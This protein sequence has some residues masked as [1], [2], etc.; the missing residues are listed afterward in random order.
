MSLNNFIS[1]LMKNLGLENIEDLE[2]LELDFDESSVENV[3]SMSKH[4]EKKSKLL[5]FNYYCSST[6]IFFNEN[7][8]AGFIIEIAPLVGINHDKLG[9]IEAFLS[10]Q[11]PQGAFMQFLMLATPKVER[12][13]GNNLDAKKPLNENHK[14][15]LKERAKYLADLSKQA[16][17]KDIKVRNFRC[18]LSFSYSAKDEQS[19]SEVCRAVKKQ[20]ESM[21]YIMSIPFLQLDAEKFID[22]ISEIISL[23]QGTGSNENI[24][25]TPQKR[26]AEHFATRKTLL[27]NYKN[28][29]EFENS[30]NDSSDNPASNTLKAKCFSI[31]EFPK[32]VEAGFMSTL[33][34]DQLRDNLNVGGK[35]ALSYTICADITETRK[36]TLSAKGA[37][38]H[39]NADSWFARRDIKLQAEANE[40]TRAIGDINQGERIFSTCIQILIIDKKIEEQEQILRSLFSINGFKIMEEKYFHLQALLGMLPMVFATGLWKQFKYFEMVKTSLLSEVKASLPIYAEWKGTKEKGMT[41]VARRGQIFSWS[42]FEDRKNYNACVVAPSG[43]GKSVFIQDF[44]FNMLS[45]NT[46]VF[47]LDIGRSY[48]KMCALLDGDFIEFKFESNI[49]LN[50]FSNIPDNNDVDDFL[51]YAKKTVCLMA[52]PT[53]NAS[54]LEKSIIEASIHTAWKKYRQETTISKIVEVLNKEGSKEALDI[55]KILYPFTK[56]GVYG[57]FFE[58]ESKINFKNPLTVIEFEEIADREELLSV[59]M[60]IVAIQVVQMFSGTRNQRFILVI[61]EAWKVMDKF[62]PLLERFVRTFRKYGG[63][64]IIATQGY[65]DFTK[66]LSSRNI[67]DN[68]QWHMFL[69]HDAASINSLRKTGDFDEDFL[70]V[71]QTVKKAPNKYSEV[72]ISSSEETVVGR[73]VLDKYSEALYST[74]A[75]NFSKMIEYKKQ[76]LSIMEIIE[77]IA[78]C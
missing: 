58:A 21:C 38:Y 55:A 67:W 56:D 61:D 16:L 28:N 25:Y 42:P 41:L 49:S 71:L 52:G 46:K 15:L 64:L 63:S 11:L 29:L 3:K 5:P 50:P 47:I 48:Q 24:K 20:I 68:S 78:E 27:Q 70:S 34:G 8:T 1:R 9:Q 32:E 40:W 31:E 36:H 2:M 7:N 37:T 66:T 65:V 33:I 23:D 60:Q 39:R 51:D 54:D 53:Q 19:L 6:G 30:L 45:H 18:F 77:R 12:I 69:A 72:L 13:L 44:I 4:T 74:K 14:S 59:V 62:A 10:S 73:L 26:I 75:E 17:D 22:L 35:F 57:R 43:S 76:G